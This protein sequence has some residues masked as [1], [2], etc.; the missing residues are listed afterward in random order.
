M[1]RLPWRRRIQS[2][3]S[4]FSLSASTD[5][6]M[7]LV[8]L[9]DVEAQSS[10]LVHMCRLLDHHRFCHECCLPVSWRAPLTAMTLGF[11]LVSFFPSML[12]FPGNFPRAPQDFSHMT[13]LRAVWLSRESFFHTYPMLFPPWRI[14]S[15]FPI[16]RVLGRNQ[17]LFLA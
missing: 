9:V 4:M 5:M 8:I 12:Y 17:N 1:L 14:V 3:W 6:H 11:S 7:A 15:C 10:P 16:S 2:R 13:P